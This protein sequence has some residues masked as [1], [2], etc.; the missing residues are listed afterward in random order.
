MSEI[1]EDTFV[2]ASWMAKKKK[3]VEQVETRF[4]VLEV[5]EF[6]VPWVPFPRKAEYATIQSTVTGMKYT[7]ETYNLEPPPQ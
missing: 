1:K 4:K 5:F 7:T 2:V 6:G 3:L